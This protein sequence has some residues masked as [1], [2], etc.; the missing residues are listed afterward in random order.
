MLGQ[1][2]Q[3]TEGLDE[4]ALGSCS[5]Q[6]G[7]NAL[8]HH[9]RDNDIKTLILVGEK[10]IEIAVDPLGGNGERSHAESGHVRGRLIEQQ[11]LL[12]LEANVDLALLGFFAFFGLSQGFFR[13][14][15]LGDLLDG[16]APARL[17]HR[18]RA[19]LRRGS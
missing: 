13:L 9:V 2:H 16:A 17:G 18:H 8:A 14:L 1:R 11:H 10:I 6:R 19:R 7:R 15:A 12:D 4:M 5:E 3:V